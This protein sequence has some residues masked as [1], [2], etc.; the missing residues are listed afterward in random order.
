MS[1]DPVTHMDRVST[2]DVHS[3]GGSD[4]GNFLESVQQDMDVHLDRSYTWSRCGDIAFQCLIETGG[5]SLFTGRDES[6]KVFCLQS[7]FWRN[8]YFHAMCQEHEF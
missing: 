5:R 1:F 2:K 6:A 7:P 8:F 3:V 4:F